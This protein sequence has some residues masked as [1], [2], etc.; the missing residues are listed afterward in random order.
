VGK[1][2][3]VAI[4]IQVFHVNFS[5][6][7]VNGSHSVFITCPC[8]HGLAGATWVVTIEVDAF[9]SAD[10][11]GLRLSVLLHNTRK[12]GLSRADNS[13]AKAPKPANFQQNSSNPVDISALPRK[14]LAEV[15][16][17]AAKWPTNGR[18]S[19]SSSAT[20]TRR[21]MRPP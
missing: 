18:Y 2:A 7:S 19:A 14:P 4:R 21:L 10:P 6:L 5:V 12:D 15:S 11:G 1:N 16:I 3:D 13:S 17:S 9:V 20:R 8:S